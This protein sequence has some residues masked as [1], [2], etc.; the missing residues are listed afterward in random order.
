[1]ILRSGLGSSLTICT[2]SRYGLKI[3]HEYGKMF[4]MTSHEVLRINPTFKEV[5]EE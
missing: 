5:T 1:M 3:S 2:V 4:Q